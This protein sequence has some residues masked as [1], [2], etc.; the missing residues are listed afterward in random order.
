MSLGVKL[1]QL[2]HKSN[3]TLCSAPEMQI[4]ENLLF[5]WRMLNLPYLGDQCVT[6]YLASSNG[7]KKAITVRVIRAE[8]GTLKSPRYVIASKIKLLVL[9]IKS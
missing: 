5:T 4:W 3:P 9:P 1:Q 7:K 8:Y 2:L 6:Q